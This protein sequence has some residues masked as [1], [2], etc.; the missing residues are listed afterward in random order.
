[1]KSGVKIR[2]WALGIAGASYH[3][4]RKAKRPNA[5]RRTQ[6]LA[7]RMT[8][9]TM[10]YILQDRALRLPRLGFHRAFFSQLP[11]CQ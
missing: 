9:T 5:K 6:E 2:R 7:L 8:C 4:K 10:P 11:A 3:S 1:M